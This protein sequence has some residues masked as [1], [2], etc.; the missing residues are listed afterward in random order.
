MQITP[1]FNQAAAGPAG[2]AAAVNR[3]PQPTGPDPTMA[4]ATTAMPDQSQ[5]NEEPAAAQ[6]PSYDMQ[7]KVS[8]GVHDELESGRANRTAPRQSA[9]AGVHD[10]FNPEAARK[11]LDVLEAGRP[12][13]AP[14]HRL[15]PPTQ[16]KKIADNQAERQRE[17]RITSIRA[18]LDYHGDEGMK[19]EHTQEHHDDLE[20]DW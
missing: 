6:A 14:H 2:D 20:L 10:A 11:E 19:R 5:T 12:K 7:N 13:P 8:A 3:G 17:Q 18:Y 15:N 16:L 9:F 1:E 4:G